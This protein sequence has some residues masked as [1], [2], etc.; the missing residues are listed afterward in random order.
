MEKPQLVNF[1][2]KV[3]EESGFKVYKNFKTSQKVID[4]YA[5]LP[6]QMGDFGVVVACNNY[7]KQW[8]VGVDIL[9]EMEMVGRNLKA[10]KVVVVT[11]S[12]FSP[13]A[14]SYASRKSINLVDRDKLISLA[15]KFSK[16]QS[17]MD[18][19][20]IDEPSK[21]RH[22]DNDAYLSNDIENSNR[23]VSDYD[24]YDYDEEDDYYSSAYLN[25]DNYYD[26]INYSRG[27]LNKSVGSS[28][29]SSYRGSLNKSVGSSSSSSSKKGLFKGF[30]F[31]R[32]SSKK[33]KSKKSKSKKPSSKKSKIK[34][35]GNHIL[36]K[37]SSVASNG[38]SIP[39]FLKPILSN[40]IFLIIVVVAISYFL[41]YLLG[42]VAKIPS[43]ITGLI[44]M[45]MSLLLSY[46][47]VY[48]V[49]KEGTAVLVKGTTVFFVS[50][51][52]LIILIIVL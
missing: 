28:S 34:A 47:L 8:E 7:D 41:A 2:A 3:M 42:V 37:S 6:T 46:G 13:Q 25:E 49:D 11:S 9:K 15:K 19:P 1:I 17:S 27:S 51:V 14:R 50:L 48:S 5:V 45:V 43:G 32:S 23:L 4:I 29:S 10:S 39:S 40:T 12:T 16:K 26:D 44:E 35:K 22:I 38:V 20:P 33:S 24:D 36:D 21:E 18:E 52:V 31:N 30:N